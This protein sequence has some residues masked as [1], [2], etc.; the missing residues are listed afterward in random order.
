MSRDPFRSFDPAAIQE[1]TRELFDLSHSIPMP[2]EGALSCPV[3]GEG[4]PVPRGWSFH[5]REGPSNPWR[6]DLSLKCVRCAHV[7]CHGLAVSE[8]A[9]EAHGDA[10]LDRRQAEAILREEGWSP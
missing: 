6:C 8:E 4:E 5:A 10:V 9:Y 2:R 1:R 3:C 7:W